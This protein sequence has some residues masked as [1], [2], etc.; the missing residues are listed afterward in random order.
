MSV[1]VGSFATLQCPQD[2]GSRPKEVFWV[3]PSGQR[4]TSND[5]KNPWCVSLS[6]YRNVSITLYCCSDA[7]HKL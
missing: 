1:F 3:T 7:L 5:T 6:I 4:I 2:I